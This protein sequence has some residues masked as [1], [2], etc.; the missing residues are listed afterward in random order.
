M[1]LKINLKASGTYPT[2]SSKDPEKIWQSLGF[3]CVDCSVL[4]LCALVMLKRERA[5]AEPVVVC[6][7]HSMQVRSEFASLRTRLVD[8]S[9]R[10]T[11]LVS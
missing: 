4:P 10:P 2:N 6:S 5:G 11:L 7:V 8:H 9:L 3:E 1:G